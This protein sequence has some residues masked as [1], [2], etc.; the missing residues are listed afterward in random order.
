MFTL[1]VFVTLEMYPESDLELVPVGLNYE[2]AVSFSDSASIY[3]GE[4]IAAKDFVYEE[5]NKAVVNLKYKI[6][7]EISKLTSHILTERYEET[8]KKLKDLEVSFLNP[9]PINE[10][11]NTGVLSKTVTKQKKPIFL[12]KV[13]KFLLIC[14]LLLPY[15]IW[16]FA[17]QPKVQDPEFVGTFRF[18]L[19][20]TLAPFWVIVV[21]L[22]TLTFFGGQI[23]LLYCC[24]SLG[25]ALLAV[26]T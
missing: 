18:A 6:Q 14:N 15:L 22:L 3:F 11:V 7:S 4:S 5:R 12:K 16:K 21:T 26:K 20:V 23:A 19:A 10:F 9:K 13:F 17:V 1:I 2:D 25:L 8:I 24:F